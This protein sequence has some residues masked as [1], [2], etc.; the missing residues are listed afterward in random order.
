MGAPAKG[1]GKAT[2]PDHCRLA[3]A[4]AAASLLAGGWAGI[5]ESPEEPL[6]G[7][8]PSNPGVQSPNPGGQSAPAR[9]N[10]ETNGTQG[11]LGPVGPF[12]QEEESQQQ[13][14]ES[15]LSRTIKQEQ[16]KPAH[17]LEPTSGGQQQ[18]GVPCWPRCIKWEEGRASWA[19][20]QE[21]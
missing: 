21:N 2:R 11:P 6:A 17:H 8:G 16:P 7:E 13:V 19:E 9:D 14:G 5:I 18:V 4:R 3:R 10:Q 20:Y 1:G 12:K 15:C